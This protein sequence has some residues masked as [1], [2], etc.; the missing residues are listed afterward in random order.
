MR[1]R[2]VFAFGLFLASCESHTVEQIEVTVPPGVTVPD[3]MVYIPAGEF[4][5]GHADEP[6]TAG[7][8][9]AATGAYLIDRFEV[10]RKEYNQEN[11]DPG[12]NEQAASLP[13]AHVTYAEAEAYCR[14]KGKRLPSEMEWEKA[15]R[16]TDGRKWPWNLYF[17]HPNNGFSGFLPEPVDKRKEWVSPYGVYGMG[18]NVWEW[19]SD[20]YAHEGQ[21]EE[22]KNRFRVIRGG[23]HQTHLTIRFTPT[24]E[25]NY[26]EPAARFNFIGFRCAKDV[27]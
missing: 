10:S 26:I 20:W 24:W 1:P 13:A 2:W 6:D 5:M 8:R 23:L 11:P 7:G 14:K 21:P 27:E 12:Y 3:G 19:T 4:I 16:G 15:A 9:K 17:D 22:E 18:Y 25:R